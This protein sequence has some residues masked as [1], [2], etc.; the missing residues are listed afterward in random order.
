MQTL[1]RRPSRLSAPG[2]LGPRLE[3]VSLCADDPDTLELRCKLV[4]KVAFAELPAE[5]LQAL[6]T[7]ELVALAKGGED[8]RPLLVGSILRRLA[9]RALARAQKKELA[10]AAGPHQYGVGRAGGASLLVKSLQALAEVRPEAAFLKVYLKAAFQTI[11]R[12]SDQGCPLAP[13]GF[14]VGQ[15]QPLEAFLD[16]LQQLDPDAKLYLSLIHI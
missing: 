15:R 9:L 5:V 12:G 7:G 11:D 6:R 10:A 8:V 3:H 1:L 13:A 4:V 2:L 16:Q 14:A